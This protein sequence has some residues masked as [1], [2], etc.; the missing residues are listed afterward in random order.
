MWDATVYQR[1]RDERA[2]PFHDL[3]ARVRADAPSYVVDLGCGPGDCTA[4]LLDRWPDATV[5]GVD[6]SPEMVAAARAHEV[7]D[8]LSFV[9]GDLRSWAAGRPVDVLV[10]NATLQWVR[11]HLDLLPRLVGMLTPGGWLGFQVP[12]NFS[13]PSHTL[14]ADLRGSARW[15]HRVGED[16]DRSAAVHEPAAYLAALA[17]LGLHADV[18][19]TTYL[20][21]L[22]GPDAVLEWTRGT[23]LR[24][25][26]A[27][28]DGAEQ[29]E[30]LSEYGERLRDAYPQGPHGTVL[31]FRRIFVV[32]QRPGRRSAGPG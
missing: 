26:L 9:Q 31:P 19:E 27:A 29:A 14:L 13:A 30:F 11:G 25:V 7:R 2:R 20:H 16:A 17:D 12:G 22:P 10:S 28:L 5:T 15:R 23:S 24:P 3:L 6:S 4:T 18:W 1:Y 32:A 8:R 21:V